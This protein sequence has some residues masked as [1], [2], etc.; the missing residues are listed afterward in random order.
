MRKQELSVSNSG[1]RGGGISERG[2]AD[3]KEEMRSTK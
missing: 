1:G 3:R 2:L